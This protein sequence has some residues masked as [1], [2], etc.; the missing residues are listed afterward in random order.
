LDYII[1]SQLFYQS[2]LYAIARLMK[3]S[4]TFGELAV[5]SQVLTLLAVEAWVIT[6][7]KVIHFS[8]ENIFW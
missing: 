8:I 6:I 7:N 5:V 3:K 2:S 4:F 1:F